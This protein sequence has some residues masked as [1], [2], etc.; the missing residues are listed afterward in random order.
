DAP[1]PRRVADRSGPPRL[2]PLRSERD[3]HQLDAG[4]EDQGQRFGPLRRRSDA[5]SRDPAARGSPGVLIYNRRMFARGRLHACLLFTAYLAACGPSVD[6]KQAVEVTDTS[7]GWYDAG[8][9]DGKN[10]IVPTVRFKLKK[11]PDADLSGV[12]LN[13]AFRYVPSA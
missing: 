12:A 3:R 9:V 13:I 7:S 4:V 5:Q 6:I 10:K 2:K 1:P 8:I 11:K